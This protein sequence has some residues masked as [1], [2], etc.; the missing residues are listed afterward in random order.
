M[1]R[2]GYARGWTWRYERRTSHLAPRISSCPPT[3][4]S[5]QEEYKAHFSMWAALKFP[6]IVG[7]D[8]R[9]LSPSTLTILNNPAVIAINQDPLGRPAGR[10]YRNTNVKKDEYGEGESKS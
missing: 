9:E 1:E 8:L 4:T 2:H 5:Q 3:N 6:L 7:H 10:I